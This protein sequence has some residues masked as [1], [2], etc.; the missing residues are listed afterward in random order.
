[1]GCDSIKE[2]NFLWDI[3]LSLSTQITFFGLKIA[4]TI[5][6]MAK[7]RLTTLIF[8]IFVPG[9]ISGNGEY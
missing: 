6:Q 1:M 2:R 7:S 3:N 4:V 5:G 8:I 9:L